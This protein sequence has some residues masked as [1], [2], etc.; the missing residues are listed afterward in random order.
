[1]TYRRPI[2]IPYLRV[3]AFFRLFL[4]FCLFICPSVCLS[5]SLTSFLVLFYYILLCLS[6]F[7]TVFT[8]AILRR[9]LLLLMVL[10]MA[11]QP[12]ACCARWQMFTTVLYFIQSSNKNQTEWFIA[13]RLA[14]CLLLPLQKI[15]LSHVRHG[16]INFYS[17][18]R[19]IYLGLLFLFYLFHCVRSYLMVYR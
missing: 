2:S 1:M 17:R 4:F 19:I 11:T 16:H 15:K 12:S 3:F 10:V 9:L 8:V 13:L 7:Y 14:M 5:F 18:S 6:I